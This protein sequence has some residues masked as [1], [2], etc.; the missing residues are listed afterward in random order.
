MSDSDDFTAEEVA[1]NLGLT[2]YPGGGFYRLFPNQEPDAERVVAY[3]LLIGG[4]DPQWT[5]MESEEMWTAYMGAPLTLEI[6][7]G[8]PVH[9]E[10]ANPGDGQWLSAP[11]GAWV[12]VVPQGAWTLAG[13]IAKPNPLVH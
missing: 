1:M 4:E 3:R 8:G 5:P 6:A 13:R 12:R 7:T 11:A 2:P 9:C 10:T